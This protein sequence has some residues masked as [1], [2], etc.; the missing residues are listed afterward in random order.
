MRFLASVI[1]DSEKLGRVIKVSC[2]TTE[3]VC[4]CFEGVVTSVQNF[5]EQA[6]VETRKKPSDTVYC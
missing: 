3:S 1:K 6:V 2:I 5:G 4:V